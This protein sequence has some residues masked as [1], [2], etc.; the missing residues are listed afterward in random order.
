M[1][2]FQ[3]PRHALSRHEEVAQ[4][5]ILPELLA[6]VV[7]QQRIQVPVLGLGEFVV[8]VELQEFV[9]LVAVLE[10]RKILTVEILENFI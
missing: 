5:M 6:Q 7:V 10:M 4:G 1:G 2:A 8:F 9:R 3:E